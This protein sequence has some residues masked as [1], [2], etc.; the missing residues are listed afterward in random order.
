ME[1][2]PDHRLKGDALGTRAKHMSMHSRTRVLEVHHGSPALTT[3]MLLYTSFPSV[4]DYRGSQVSFYPTPPVPLRF[5]RGLHLLAA[6]AA[7]MLPFAL[8][9]EAINR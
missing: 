5:T 9:A 2:S 3:C 8:I 1:L 7:K 6:T 4:A